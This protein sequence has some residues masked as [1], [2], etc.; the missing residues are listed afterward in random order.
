M[1][2]TRPLLI[3]EGGSAMR[4]KSCSGHSPSSS[5]LEA[6]VSFCTGPNVR[7]KTVIELKW[8][9]HSEYCREN[10][11]LII[12]MLHLKHWPSQKKT[13]QGTSSLAFFVWQF[14]F[15]ATMENDL[16]IKYHL[17]TQKQPYHK[18]RY[19]SKSGALLGT[20]KWEID[21]AY[22]T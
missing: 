11:G 2:L 3:T 17:F 1:G 7:F 5:I 10:L 21:L 19:G 15:W 14:P 18:V 8:R 16:L 22:M 20:A 4:T 9:M 13:N 6:F 12:H